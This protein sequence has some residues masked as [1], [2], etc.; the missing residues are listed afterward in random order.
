MAV[1]QNTYTGNGSNTNF[2]ITFE[3]LKQADVKA[4][5]DGT[6]T[7]AFTLSNATTLSFN[8]APANGAAVRIFRDTDISLSLIHI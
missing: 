4:S 5:I 6:A 2:S 1:T 3:Y 8:T 7:T